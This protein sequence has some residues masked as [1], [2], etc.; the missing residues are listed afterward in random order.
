[1]NVYGQLVAAQFENRT[2]DYAQGVVGRTWARTDTNVL[3]VDIGGSIKTLATTDV[4]FANPMTTLG[5]MV[6]GGASGA[7]TRLAPPTTDGAWLVY[8]LANTK[9]AWGRTTV[10]EDSDTSVATT[11]AW[12][13]ARKTSGTAA[14]GFGGRIELSVENASGNLPAAAYLQWKL[15]TATNG[16]EASALSFWTRTGG[17]ALTENLSISGTGIVQLGKSV[18]DNYTGVQHVISGGLWAGNVTST[19]NSGRLAIGVN[20]RVSSQNAEA[21]RTDSTSGGA[22]IRF[23]NDT[24]ASNNA[25]EMIVN[26]AGDATSAS[27]D[28]AWVVDYNGRIF[29]GI[30]GGSQSHTTYMSNMAWTAPS[31]T[32]VTQS[33][34]IGGT[35]YGYWGI[36]G[37]SNSIIN[38]S[39]LGDA[40][41]RSQGGSFLFSVNSGT[42]AICKMAASGLTTFTSTDTSSSAVKIN[43]PASFTYSLG[44]L[45]VSVATNSGTGFYI[46][47]WNTANDTEM[48]IRGDGNLYVD[49]TTI[50]GT[51]DYAEYFESASGEELPIGATVVFE[52]D[53]VRVAKDGDNPEDV[54]GV[55][56]PVGASIV[57]NA[58]TNRWA[59]KYMRDV[60]GAYLTDEKGGR[61]LNPKFDAK[62]PYVSREE[63]PEWSIIGLV[64]QV[65]ILKGS[66]THPNWR[67]ME[68]VGEKHERWFIR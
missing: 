42:S 4:A 65:V 22:A 38:G 44:A 45:D 23:L 52:G 25:I 28:N 46:Q 19:N 64:G 2:S 9:P 59:N 30:S 43:S 47:S 8:D 51:A 3:K 61:I 35:L 40:V 10:Y 53:K 20:C 58:A 26:Q 1:M 15:T 63:R 21:A 41:I 6:Y 11:T 5:D 37:A 18:T 7:A 57:A 48:R 29:A 36:S 67:K 54:F 31:A 39:T 49:N 55:V 66:V 34:H 50:A 27:G 24:T 33:W 68:D 16:G 62:A 14:A 60:F 56:R 17:G 12:S 32:T 13:F